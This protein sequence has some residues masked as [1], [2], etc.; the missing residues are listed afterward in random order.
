[1]GGLEKLLL[2]VH[3]WTLVTLFCA[4]FDSDLSSNVLTCENLKPSYTCSRANM[5]ADVL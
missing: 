2:F 5:V 1:V 3:A 4:M